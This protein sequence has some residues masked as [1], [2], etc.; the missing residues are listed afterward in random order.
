LLG[1]R[2]ART[3]PELG[4]GMPNAS[5]PG[6]DIEM[7]PL[8]IDGSPQASPGIPRQRGPNWDM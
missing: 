4:A 1:Q 6:G 5:A 2:G 7:P 8:P 3:H